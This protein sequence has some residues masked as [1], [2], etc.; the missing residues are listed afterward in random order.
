VVSLVL[1]L[2]AKK[3]ESLLPQNMQRK[4][5]KEKYWRGGRGVWIVGR[6]AGMVGPMDWQVV[7]MAEGMMQTPKRKCLRALAGERGSQADVFSM[8]VCGN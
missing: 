4:C 7:G 2:E 8:R 6:G 5:G 3:S 1:G